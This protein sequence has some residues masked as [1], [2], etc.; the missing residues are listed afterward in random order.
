M[1]DGNGAFCCF[2]C[3]SIERGPVTG[4]G[5]RCRRYGEPLENPAAV[6]CRS[7]ALRQPAVF[8]SH[9][10]S[11]LRTL[12]HGVLVASTGHAA[13]DFVPVRAFKRKTVED[14]WVDDAYDALEA[15]LP[16][17]FFVRRGAN[18]LYEIVLDETV[19]AQP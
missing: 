3:R 6:I 4:G 18:L 9:E 7:F 2:S 15:A 14:R 10:R 13:T 11:I 1:P 19:K 16:A 8:G 5:D 12:P 17:P